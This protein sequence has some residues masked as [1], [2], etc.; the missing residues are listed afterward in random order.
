MESWL[1]FLVDSHPGFGNQQ[2]REENR[3]QN[4]MHCSGGNNRGSA[5]AAPIVRGIARKQK[6]EFGFR[7]R[8]GEFLRR[9]GF[10]PEEEFSR[11][12]PRAL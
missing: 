10:H 5:P 12:R 7:V 1:P 6:M 9:Y 2:K 3:K 4:D 11:P 8:R